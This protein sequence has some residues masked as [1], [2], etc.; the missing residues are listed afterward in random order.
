MA[1]LPERSRSYWIDMTPTTAYP[2]LQGDVAVDVAV[3][4][5][6]LVGLTAALLLKQADRKVAVIESRRVAEGVTG[7]TTAKVTAQHGL[8]YAQIIDKSGEDTAR[9]S[10]TANQPAIQRIAGIAPAPRPAPPL[11]PNAT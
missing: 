4:G 2:P 11:T 10:A 1:S 3:V 9:N 8:I 7:H 6:G 5:G